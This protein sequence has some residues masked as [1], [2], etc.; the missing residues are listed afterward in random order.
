MMMKKEILKI[1]A[2]DLV[3]TG[4][5]ILA[6]QGALPSGKMRADINTAVDDARKLFVELAEPKAIMTEIGAAEFDLIYRGTGRNS[7]PALLDFILPQASHL[8]L[9]AATVGQKVTQ[10]IGELFESGDFLLGAMLDAAAS[11]GAD[12]ASRMLERLFQDRLTAEKR[13]GPMDEV[14]CYSPGYCG[15]HISAQRQLFAYLQPGVIGLSL[16]DSFL[17]EPVKSISGV[18]VAGSADIHQFD[19][20]FPFCT[21][22]RTRSCRAR[23]GRTQKR[24]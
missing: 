7:Q 12:E 5:S 3:P 9:I 20:T 24:Q 14:F 15:W 6:A 4:D 16:R 11:G 18:L 8:A 17:M 13:I 21:E 2:A 22:C 1:A 23:M 10:R 19:D